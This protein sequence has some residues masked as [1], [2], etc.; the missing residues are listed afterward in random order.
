MRQFLSLAYLMGGGTG[1]SQAFHTH[2]ANGDSWG[3][4]C[5]LLSKGSGQGCKLKCDSLPGV[6][7]EEV[8]IEDDIW[9]LPPPFLLQLRK[10][11]GKQGLDP[12]GYLFKEPGPQH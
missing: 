10:L 3:G 4:N 2:L 5:F 6:G 12:V 11:Q 9:P 8:L 7:Q 1:F